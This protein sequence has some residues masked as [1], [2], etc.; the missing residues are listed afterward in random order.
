MWLLL[1][2]GLE[3]WGEQF[4]STKLSLHS[5]HLDLRA[6]MHQS[7]Q[8]ERSGGYRW[9][10]SPWPGDGV[11]CTSASLSRVTEPLLTTRLCDEGS[12]FWIGRLAIRSILFYA[13]RVSATSIHSSP[14]PSRLP[15]H[16]D[17]L[18]YL[19]CD[20]PMEVIDVTSLSGPYVEGLS[21]GE[22]VAKRNALMAG[23]AK[24][25]FKYAF[26]ETVSTPEGPPSPPMSLDSDKGDSSDLIQESRKEALRLATKSVEPMVELTSDLLGDRTVVDPR[27]SALSL[28]GGLWNSDGYRMLFLDTLKKV[29]IEFKEVLVVGDPGGEGAK[30]LARVE[31]D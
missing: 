24:V 30:G 23:A 27:H 20:N 4:G 14:T 19:G 28:G 16:N 13:D 7:M 25:V 6:S 2:A 9:R 21:V 11:I 12:A 5:L 8:G 26:P 22:A 31:F 29:G 18:E 17:L 10:M 1:F 15:L 3:L